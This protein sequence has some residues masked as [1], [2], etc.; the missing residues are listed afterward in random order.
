M[1]YPLY[2]IELIE[3]YLPNVIITADELA[4]K[5]GFDPEFVSNKIGVK[6]LYIAEDQENTSD[7]AVQAMEKLLE[8]NPLL[9]TEI[10]ALVVCTQTPDFQL[11]QMSAL[12][13]SRCKL[14]RQ[15]AAFDINLGCSGF[16]Y[17]VSI[18]ESFLL[19]NG[20][21]SGVLITAETYSKIINSKDRNTKPLFSDAASATLISRQGKVRFGKS[22]FG[23]NGDQF[24]ALIVKRPSDGIRP[25][26]FMDGR[27]IF[28]FVASTIPGEVR[29]A[30]VANDV[31]LD[32]IDYFVFH[33]ASKFVLDTLA[34]KLGIS[35]ASRMINTIGQYGNTVSSS[36]PMALKDTLALYGKRDLKLLISGFGVGLSWGTAVISTEGDCS[37]V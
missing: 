37:N 11:P 8:R 9:R 26:L 25:E 1:T 16:A 24:C 3:T 20:M 29:S 27:K 21:N 4:S 18:L 23:T 14:P 10:D 17:G 32:D 36:I 22:K 19:R 28:E 33:Q 5:L 31:E 7:L 35:D 12:I 13:Q 6:Q 30:C 2:G 34:Q 15:M